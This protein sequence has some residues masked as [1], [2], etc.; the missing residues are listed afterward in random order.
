MQHFSWVSS[1]LYLF[2]KHCNL[3][4]LPI[5]YRRALPDPLEAR[6]R[7]G[8]AFFAIRLANALIT[9]SPYSPTSVAWRSGLLFMCWLATLVGVALNS[10][11]SV[12]RVPENVTTL[13]VPDLSI[14]PVF[15]ACLCR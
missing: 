8:V 11:N 15:A 7:I 10:A 9:G 6:V 12:E 5:R 4:T 1:Y 3:S 13:G 2:G 14:V